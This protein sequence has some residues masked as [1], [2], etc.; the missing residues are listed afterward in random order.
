MRGINRTRPRVTLC[1]LIE[2]MVLFV[3][4]DA[5]ATPNTELQKRN[6]QIKMLSIV[7]SKVC[8]E[9]EAESLAKICAGFRTK[10]LIMPAG[11]LVGNTTNP[12]DCSLEKIRSEEQRVVDQLKSQYGLN[13]L[14]VSQLRS[15]LLITEQVRAE[16]M[17]LRQDLSSFKQ[18]RLSA[19]SVLQDD[20]IEYSQ[21]F[22]T[23]KKAKALMEAAKQFSTTKARISELFS[24]EVL[25]LM[26]SDMAE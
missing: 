22:D 21:L 24:P 9:R 15:C 13:S 26:E 6:T 11:D 1:L 10:A 8:N 16:E 5:F 2:I 25:V 3:Q 7:F 17:K 12:N 23:A 18:A 14:D 20:S 19:Q 4:S